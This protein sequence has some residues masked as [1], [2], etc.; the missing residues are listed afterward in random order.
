M[1]TEES[2]R[3]E[4]KA[5][6]M[7]LLRQYARHH[8]EEAFAALVSRHVNLVYSATLRQ[9][10]DAHSAEEITQAVFI[11][12]A[13]KA[14]GLGPGT[15]L[16][17]WLHRT[18]V[19]VAA[20]ALKARRR[21][22][23]REQEASMEIVLNEPA[24]G[25]TWAQIAPMLDSALARLADK[26][27]AAIV[28]RFF[29]NRELKQVGAALGVS[30]EAAK[31]RVSRAL[32]KLR[33]FFLQRGV[34]S[35]AAAI[36]ETISTNAIQAAPAAL[37]KSVTAVALAKGAAAST[38]TLTLIKGALKIMTWTKAKTMTATA[39]CLVLVC[40]T[41][42]VIIK[43]RSAK[44]HALEAN[45]YTRAHLSDPK[46]EAMVA[47][48]RTKTWPAERKATEAK[49]ASRQQ[50]NETVNA[51]TID[52]RRHINTALA[53]SPPT[54]A[55]NKDD[56]LAELPVGVHNFGG[57]PF[58]VEGLIQLNGTNMLA[59]HKNYPAEVNGI[60]INRKCA[61]IYLL[62]GADWIYL[63]DF[64][65]TVARLVLHYEDGSERQIDIVAGKDVFDSWGPLFTTGVDPRYF[66]MAP[67]TERAWT[68]SN[69][70]IRKTWPDESLILYRSAFENP[71]PGATVSTLDYV[72]TMTGTAP[73]LV[74][75]TVE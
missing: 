64:G 2:R 57:V 30:E 42:F 32:E 49:I 4:M 38:S 72:S 71:Q 18:A 27:R 41:T 15:I 45:A 12:L 69:P 70:A 48:L 50:V 36:G 55:G 24:A 33:R 62:H 5:G 63:H 75:L 16:P 67:G 10:G 53:D 54:S 17:S 44:Y 22:A 68:G 6:D 47:S 74:G 37:A 59:A 61:T 29:E 52:L 39:L 19:F 56:N 13:R 40:G 26:D 28:L 66:Q 65:K 1:S 43:E 25:A 60:T 51:T 14:G 20:D 9:T 34:D 7:E 11:I 21:R 31:K 73:F 58:D 3:N 23:Q 35:T 8:S 46:Y